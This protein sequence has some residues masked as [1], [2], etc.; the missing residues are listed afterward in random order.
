[1]SDC[2]S[3]DELVDL[4]EG[5]LAPDQRAAAFEHL[6]TCTSCQMALAAAARSTPGQTQTTEV[7][8]G[9]PAL[10]PQPLGKAA[11]PV[12]GDKLGRYLLLD[13]LGS[14]GMGVVFRAYDPSLDRK[15][16][17]KLLRTAGWDAAAMTALKSRLQREAQAMARLTHPN[18]LPVHDIGQEGDQVYVAIELVDGTTLRGWL[19]ERPRTWREV[20]RAF[21]E[22]GRGLAAAHRAGLV[23]RDFKPDN[24]LVGKDGRVRVTD[25]GLVRL[26]LAEA[27]SLGDGEEITGRSRPAEAVPQAS[28][29]AS[30]V[31]RAGAVLGTPFYM[32][33]EQFRGEPAGAAADQ[34]AFCVSLWEAL[35]GEPPFAGRDV[36]ERLA[37]IEKAEVRESSR[38]QMPLWLRRG[39]IKGLS[40]KPSARYASMDALLERIDRDPWHRVRPWVY[41]GA[42]AVA[43]LAGA[44]WLA[45]APQRAA[46]S[47]Q[48]ARDGL[49]D[50]WGPAQ[51]QAIAD[52]FRSLG[53]PWADAVGARTLAI[54]DRYADT[55]I[56]MQTD[57]CEAS[58]VRHEQ[59]LEMYER[60]TS[61]LNQRRV[62]L[63]TL[64]RMLPEFDATQAELATS[65]AAQLSPI[66]ECADARLLRAVE[67]P[68]SPQQKALA[69]EV[70]GEIAQGRALALANREHDSLAAA[71]RSVDHAKALGDAGVL[72]S[73]LF[74]Q[75]WAMRMVGHPQ[76]AQPV[77]QNAAQQALASGL[78]PVAAEA[79][80]QLAIID[81]DT[82][83]Y[84]RAE[85]W[86]RYA[87][88][89]LQAVG[90]ASTRARIDL[91]ITRAHLRGAT[92][93]FDEALAAAQGAQRALERSRER[94]PIDES[95]VESAFAFAY[96]SAGKGADALPHSK[97]A[98]E[99]MSQA[100]GPGAPLLS[101][102]MDEYGSALAAAK[103]FEEA[104]EQYRAAE[105]LSAQATNR[106]LHA[107][108]ASNVAITLMEAGHLQESI[109]PLEAS[110][111]EQTLL[112]GKEA[113]GTLRTRYALALVRFKQGDFKKAH[114]ELADILSFKGL[115]QDDPGEVATFH[116]LDGQALWKL[117]DKAHALRELKAGIEVLR[118]NAGED[119]DANDEV[120]ELEEWLRAENVKLD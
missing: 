64:A 62:E 11:A 109:E 47:C 95:I 79:W 52:H 56:A 30:P 94:D 51:R 53:K 117:G 102:Q 41:G 33:P 6:D 69:D 77:L 75:G 88:A 112:V 20:L 38:K 39:I 110:I 100:L 73:A 87:D 10:A 82:S 67:A 4:A 21:C 84:E 14:G 101:R 18:V 40:D 1:M 5:R 60:R 59:T 85:Q 50:V 3:E 86:C 13:V 54:L 16:A 89:V 104:L 25:F 31:T 81:F 2:L 108:I 65:V 91:D 83:T 57:A 115:A 44:A 36:K 70:Y 45:T 22:A 66:D 23:H 71:Q 80:T 55:W 37:H 78:L 106:M 58:R 27:Q 49:A 120:R 42:A 92:G 74:R 9:E 34:F 43:L 28:A 17:I 76:D 15:V 12:S 103:R 72:A 26:D 68:K 63:A 105:K 8:M 93:H 114:A 98:L 116:V 90:D 46:A 48:G 24:V 97:R 99:R 96:S 32:A 61:C 118:A 119:V 29:L 35:T 111:A 7:R 107:V 113:I 19:R